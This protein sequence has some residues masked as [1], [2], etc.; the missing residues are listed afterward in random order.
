[1]D[2]TYVALGAARAVLAG[3][4]GDVEILAPDVLADSLVELAQEILARYRLTPA[5]GPRS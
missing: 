2:L 5:D 3:F 1:L 4:G